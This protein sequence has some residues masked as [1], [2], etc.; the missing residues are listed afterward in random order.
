[1]KKL[2][3]L[4][5]GII[6]LGGSFAFALPSPVPGPFFSKFQNWENFTTPETWNSVNEELNQWGIAEDNW[7]VLRVDTYR[8]GQG[9]YEAIQG[10]P[11]VAT[12][13]DGQGGFEIT[14]MFYGIDIVDFNPASGLLGA[15][16]GKLDLY[17][18]TLGTLAAEPLATSRTAFNQYTG[19]T[20]GQLLLS[21]DFVNNG[22]YTVV[23]ENAMLVNGIPVGQASSYLKITD[24]L[25][26]DFFDN[27]YFTLPNDLTAA[28]FST[29][30]F[31][32]N[33]SLTPGAFQVLSNDP[34]RGYVVPEP[35]SLLL[36]GAGFLGL[37]AYGRRRKS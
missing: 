14:G 24:G 11:G 34:L 23:A 13:N 32:A 26:K 2:L 19:I 18:N 36:L 7:G 8:Q 1:M 5:A 12:W 30:V 25:W 27:D 15:I 3:A 17:V 9:S 35:G 22:P 6:L 28:F 33:T 20:G 31:L 4:V 16:G 21:L 37:A 29:N 10:L